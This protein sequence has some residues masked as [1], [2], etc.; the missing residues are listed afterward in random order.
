MVP[1]HTKFKCDGN[2][3]LIKKLYRKTT[4]DCVNHIVEIVKKSSTTGLN[5]AQRYDNGKG[6]QYLDLNSVLRIFFKKLSG[7]QKYQHF[8]FEAANPGVVK[9]QTVA[10]GVFTEFNLLKP[11]KTTVSEITR[12]IK[13]FSILVLT[14]PP[15]DCK[16]QEYLYHNICP[17]VRD[18]FKDI[19]C[20]QPIYTGNE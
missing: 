5:K 17:F 12:E 11:R 18:K 19:T 6:F 7:L 4:V 20:P 1:G 14:P 8:V 15:L 13:S 3:G 2:F 9:A 16:R 10:N